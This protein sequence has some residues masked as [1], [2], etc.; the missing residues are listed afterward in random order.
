MNCPSRTDEPPESEGWNQNPPRLA[1]DLT[2]RED[3]NGMVNLRTQHNAGQGEDEPAIELPEMELLPENCSES[4][5]GARGH[6]SPSRIS[7]KQSKDPFSSSSKI[8]TFSSSPNAM[9]SIWPRRQSPKLLSSFRRLGRVLVKFGKFVGPGFMIS[10][11]Y[12][13]PGNYST[14]VAAGASTRF[15]LLFIIFM[16]N[17]FAILLQSLA[18][19]LGTVTGLNLAENCRAHLPRWLNIILYIMGE[20]AIIATDIAEVC[21]SVYRLL[22]S[23]NTVA[24]TIKGHWIRN[25]AQPTSENT[26]S[27]GMCTHPGRRSHHSHFL[28]SGRHYA[29]FASI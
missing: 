26:P 11:A 20:A 13:D 1:A 6:V 8:P 4:S 24:N 15:R 25:S 28:Q 23:S 27:S 16:S 9:T 12:I 29:A 22:K 10:V 7:G 18:V 19:R 14:D 2:T 3:L 17:V 5:L 21:F